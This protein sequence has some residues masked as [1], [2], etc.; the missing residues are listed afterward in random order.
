M[1]VKAGG[2]LLSGSQTAHTAVSQN[3]VSNLSPLITKYLLLT[4]KESRI[5]S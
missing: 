2:N 1:S 4:G 5:Y 3:F